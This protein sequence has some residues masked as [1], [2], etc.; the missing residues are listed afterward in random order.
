MCGTMK[1]TGCNILTKEDIGSE[2][3]T[4]WTSNLWT[5]TPK[6]LQLI[7]NVPFLKALD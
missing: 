2:E 7:Q 1:I 5:S 6:P 4:N 3:D